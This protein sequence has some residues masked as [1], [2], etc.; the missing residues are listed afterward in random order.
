MS[1]VNAIFFGFVQ[2]ITEIL[3]LSSGA[4]L[5]IVGNLFGVSS[6]AFNYKIF[7]IF[8]HFGTIISLII[9]YWDEIADMIFEIAL[10]R[11]PN[12][13]KKHYPS[14]KLLYMIFVSCL[15]LFLGLVFFNQ[16]EDLYVN[17][18]F[19]GV[20]LILNGSLLI[21]ADKFIKCDKDIAKMTRT[22]ALIIGLCQLVSMV[23]G[24]SRIG[25][26]TS[27]GMSLGFR[28]DFSF[29]YA[30][31]MSLPVSIC[32]NMYHIVDASQ[33]GFSWD[34]LPACLIGMVASIVTSYFAI[35]IMQNNVKKGKFN[36]FSYYCFVA[37]VIFIILTMIF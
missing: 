34:M 17:S 13:T 7:S 20:S 37:G 4:H 21:V 10:M 36:G 9:A 31:L 12:H 33:L 27:A 22:D 23:P 11:S 3:P 24:I 28:R 25:T 18:I 8:V 19:I 1:I 14:V 26:V 2:G 30:A 5:A 15:P 16:I 29:R 6:G 32:A 35:K